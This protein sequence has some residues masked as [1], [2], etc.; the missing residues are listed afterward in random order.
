MLAGCGVRSRCRRAIS[1]W[2]CNSS[3]CVGAMIVQIG[4]F[5]SGIMGLRGVAGWE[6]C[7]MD[8]GGKGGSGVDISKCLISN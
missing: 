4:T 2:R 6:D 7:A 3:A 8:R 1:V 5:V